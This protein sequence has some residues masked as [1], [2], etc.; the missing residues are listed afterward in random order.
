MKFKNSNC[1]K[2]QKIKLWSN[3]KNSNGDKTQN[4]RLSQNP[5]TEII[6]SKSAKRNPHRPQSLC[7][8]ADLPDLPLICQICQLICQI[9]QWSANDLPDLPLIFQIYHWSARS[10]NDL[11]DLTMICQIFLISPPHHQGHPT[12]HRFLLEPFPKRIAFFLGD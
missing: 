6:K 2:T 10:A 9:C 5:N 4:V 12:Y 7:L 3:Y 11:P 1:D 8:P